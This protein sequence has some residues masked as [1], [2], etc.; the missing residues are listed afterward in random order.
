MI[1]AWTMCVLLASG[2][3]CL[4]AGCGAGPAPG[5]AG[6]LPLIGITSSYKP[7]VLSS[8]VAYAESI[9]DAGG[10][11]VVLPVIADEKLIGRYARILDGLVLSGGDD[12]PPAAY[13]EKSH[14]LTK[15]IS[16]KRHAFEDALVKAW[17]K[18]RKPLLGICRG[19][20]QV[21]VSCGGTL[22]QDI[23]SQVGTKVIHQDRSRPGDVAHTIRIEHGSRLAEMFPGGNIRV[24]SN[25]HQAARDVGKGLKVTARS[26]DGLIE[27]IEFTDG[28]FGLLVQWHPERIGSARHKKV[29]FGAFVRACGRER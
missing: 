1:P 7:G 27:A 26:A 12:L 19:C 29:L 22:V 2:V 15:T 13:G 16:P 24:N 5:A 18:T 21:N 23:R 3:A 28:R 25:H 4:V 10:V 9:R 8:S 6:R 14:R 17:L 11:P 20:Q